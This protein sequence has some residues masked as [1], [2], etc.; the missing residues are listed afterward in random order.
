[1][2]EGE[3]P[4]NIRARENEMKKIHAHQITLKTF[5]QRLNKFI[6][7]Q[8]FGKKSHMRPENSPSSQ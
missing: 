8:C 4:K 7:G 5:M 6:Q 1:M 2:A 3:V